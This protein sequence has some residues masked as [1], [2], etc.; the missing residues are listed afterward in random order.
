[1]RLFCI[2]SV[3][4]S[5]DTGRTKVHFGVMWVSEKKGLRKRDDVPR[6]RTNVQSGV[7][8]NLYFAGHIIGVVK[9]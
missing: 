9:S 6:R 2:G 7:L 3:D 4:S 5:F 8:H 1:V